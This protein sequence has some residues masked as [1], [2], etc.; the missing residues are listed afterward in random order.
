MKGAALLF[1]P[2]V[3]ALVETT[4]EVEEVEVPKMKMKDKAFHKQT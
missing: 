2:E 4:L 3:D 1:V